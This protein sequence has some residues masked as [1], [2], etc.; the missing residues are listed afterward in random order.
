MLLEP[1]VPALP[2]S[3]RS[4][5]AL[6][7]SSVPVK[8]LPAVNFSSFP[9]FTRSTLSVPLPLMMLSIVASEFCVRVYLESDSSTSEPFPLRPLPDCDTPFLSVTLPPSAMSSDP[10][11]VPKALFSVRL[12]FVPPVTVVSPV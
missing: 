1:S 6:M 4:S 12:T 2:L 10:A 9:S 8:D 7:R 11:P 3:V 5:A